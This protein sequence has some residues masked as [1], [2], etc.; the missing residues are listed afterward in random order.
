MEG[1]PEA[2]DFAAS[3][4]REDFVSFQCK[5]EATCQ[6]LQRQIAQVQQDFLAERHKIVVPQADHDAAI[7]CLAAQH[8]S[9]MAELKSQH[10]AEAKGWEA[11]KRDRDSKMFR[12]VVRGSS[13]PL[14][15]GI[16]PVSIFETE[17]ASVL[18]VMYTG[19]WDYAKDAQ[20]RAIV[21]SDPANWPIILN[22]LSFGAVPDK[23]TASLLSECRYWQLEK[24]LE[25]MDANAADTPCTTEN[26]TGSH[27]LSVNAVTVDSNKGFTVRG[28][29]YDFAGRVPA[30]ADLSREQ[31]S[32]LN[33]PFVAAGRNWRMA[34]G[35]SGFSLHMLTGQPLTKSLLKIECGCSSYCFV[36]WCSK[37][38]TY[39]MK[40]CYGWEEKLLMHQSMLT[41]EGSLP[42]TL[43]VTYRQ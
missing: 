5:M 27:H 26:V 39:K 4:P 29:I 32:G 40:D 14:L 31:P 10:A 30:A 12:Y 33:I 37:E 35:Q 13:D 15:N 36:R 21:N 38:Y 6:S 3:M 19:E 20:G 23:P 7:A 34:F 24:L 2:Q 25:A 22:W 41:D 1:F 42:F 18:A 43:T 16:V 9:A 17:L 28:E 11:A 8:S